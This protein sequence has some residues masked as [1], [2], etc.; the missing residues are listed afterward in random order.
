MYLQGLTMFAKYLLRSKQHTLLVWVS[1]C[2]WHLTLAVCALA[3]DL[4]AVGTLA[5]ELSAGGVVVLVVVAV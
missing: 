5:V 4:S 1:V 2:N 3:W